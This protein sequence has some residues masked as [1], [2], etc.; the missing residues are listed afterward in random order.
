MKI[1]SGENSAELVVSHSRFIG[2]AGP[3]D[4]AMD[5]KRIAACVRQDHR[6]CSHV[7]YAFATGPMGDEC[8]M[9]DDGEPKG[10]A[11]RPVLELIR[12][13]GVTDVIITIVRYFG[14][15]K[16]GTGGLVR[17][18]TRTAQLVL[19]TLPLVERKELIPFAV[20]AP[21]SGYDTAKSIILRAGGTLDR[22][23]FDIDVKIQGLLPSDRVE[24]C[25]AELLDSSAGK[26]RLRSDYSSGTIVSKNE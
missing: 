10:T 7:V 24:A 6:K 25:A 17:A 5:A 9:T 3:Y 13:S 11:G 4:K 12:R 16:L 20:E 19:E 15:T 21:Y 22:E 8:G 2:H 18:Y 14:G 1:P 23:L 26:I